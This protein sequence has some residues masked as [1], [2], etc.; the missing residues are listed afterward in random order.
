MPPD[1]LVRW[2]EPEG[3]RDRDALARWC[4]TIGPVLLQPLADGTP[5]PCIDRLAVMTWNV[6][7]GSG[8]VADVVRRLRTGEFTGGVPVDHSSCC[9]RK[10]T[11]A[12]PPSRHKSH[13]V[14]PRPVAS[15]RESA[16]ARTS[17]MSRRSWASRLFYVPAMRN[18]IASVD[19][20]DR[21]NAILSTLDLH[22]PVIVELPM[23]NQRRTAVVAT[24]RAQARDGSPWVIRMANVHLDTALAIT[25]GGPFAARRRQAH[26][27]IDS[28]R[29]PA[30]VP[31]VLAGDFNTWRG[32]TE[33]A[34]NILRSAF[35]ETPRTVNAETWRGPL[36]IRAQLDYMFMRGGLAEARVQRLPSRFGS[37]HYPL[38][39][40]VGVAP[41]EAALSD[42]R[43]MIPKDRSVGCGGGPVV[44]TARPELVEGRTANSAH[45]PTACPAAKRSSFDRL[46]MSGESRGSP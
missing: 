42:Q 41:V 39:A 44:C 19:P 20:E 9:S 28:L 21:G 16:A 1:A 35:P 46:R 5:P 36:G 26:A 29:T 8:N 43:S 10:R 31:T 22:D 18:G 7:V 12:T 23:E 15:R 2:V 38:L 40:I 33:P 6:H 27:L 32:P 30:D 14:F 24:V 13:A 25:R 11:G 34:L 4:D 17:A 37:D 45:G 3:R